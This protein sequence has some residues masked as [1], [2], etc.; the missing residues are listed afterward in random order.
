MSYP[1]PRYN[2]EADAEAH[3][4]AFLTTWQANH[5]SQRL[6]VLDANASKIVEFRLSLDGQSTSSYSQHNLTKFQDFDQLKDS[7]SGC[8]KC[9]LMSQFYMIAQEALETVP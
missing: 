5:V 1:Y 7:S 2:D 6:A 8:F 4:H 9:E 3:V